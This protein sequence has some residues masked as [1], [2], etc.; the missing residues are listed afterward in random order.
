MQVNTHSIIPL[1]TEKHKYNKYV[2]VCVYIY[3]PGKFL[4]EYLTR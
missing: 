1:K 4:E 3:M 2:N